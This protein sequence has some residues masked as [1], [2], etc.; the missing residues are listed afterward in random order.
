MISKAQAIKN[1]T[2]DDISKTNSQIKKEVFLAY[3]LK[4]ESNQIIGVLGPEKSRKWQG[5]VWPMQQELA[6]EYL[7]KIGDI[8]LAIRLIY[9]AKN[10]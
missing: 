7:E 6:R 3:G 4:V 2:K 5:M 1:V 10:G 8:Q 9:S